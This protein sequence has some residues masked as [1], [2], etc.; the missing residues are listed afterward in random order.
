MGLLL[1]A[2]FHGFVM[3]CVSWV[4]HGLCLMGSVCHGLSVMG[5]L[6]GLSVMGCVSWGLSWA[7]SQGV[8]LSWAVSWG[9]SWAVSWGLSWTVS[10]G[11]C[12]GLCLMGSVMGCVSGG[13]SVMGCL[14]GSVM[15]VSH[16]DCNG[17]CLTRF[18]SLGVIFSWCWSLERTVYCGIF[19]LWH[20]SRSVCP[21][22]AVFH[23][24]YLMGSVLGSLSHGVSPSCFF[25][26]SLI[27][28]CLSWGM[29]HRDW[30]YVMFFLSLSHGVCLIGTG[31]TS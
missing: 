15:A 13:L 14:M 12:H 31:C 2:V 23:A 3:G 28:F 16:G 11:V 27:G 17:L 30:V 8:C 5:C 1:W 22:R 24:V 21:M 29:P 26:F 4:C 20:M 25:S 10:R 19:L 18:V 9:L 7:V 6:M